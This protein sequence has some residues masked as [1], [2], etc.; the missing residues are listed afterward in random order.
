MTDII[1]QLQVFIHKAFFYDYLN[2]KK[3]ER[4]IE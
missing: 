1:E 3:N 4:S 2:D